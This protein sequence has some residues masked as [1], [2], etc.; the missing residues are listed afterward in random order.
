MMAAMCA[1]TLLEA[2]RTSRV[3]TGSAAA[4]VDSTA[5]LNGL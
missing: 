1:F 2:M 5:L 3:T 4:I